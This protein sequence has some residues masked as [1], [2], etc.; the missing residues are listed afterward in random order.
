MKKSMQDSTSI[1]TIQDI[2]RVS[3]VCI[4]FN[5][6]NVIIHVNPVEPK[7]G[8]RWAY[9]NAA[10]SW[11]GRLYFIPDLESD[12]KSRSQYGFLYTRFFFD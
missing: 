7:H 9:G 3:D 10:C 5:G 4:T 1:T 11:F 12:D 8:L 2:L 6:R